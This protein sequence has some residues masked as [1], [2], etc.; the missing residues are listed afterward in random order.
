[1][2]V[3]S[4]VYWVLLGF[5]GFYWVLLGFTEFYRVLLGF[6][7]FYFVLMGF[8]GSYWKMIVSDNDQRW[9]AFK[10]FF[11]FFLGCWKLNEN[12]NNLTIQPENGEN[13]LISSDRMRQEIKLKIFFCRVPF[14]RK[15]NRKKTRLRNRSFFS[16]IVFVL[17]RI[18]L[19]MVIGFYWFLLGF[20]GF[21]RVSPSFTEFY[22]VLPSF[23]EFYWVLLDLTGFYWVLLGFTGFYWVLLVFKI[24]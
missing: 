14:W 18:W 9:E 4:V 3:R 20:T 15:K 8:T 13:G 19:I 22:R 24:V 12:P 11:P 2:L 21:Y 16:V 23:T 5:T 1:M 7:G 6:T 10:L 17:F